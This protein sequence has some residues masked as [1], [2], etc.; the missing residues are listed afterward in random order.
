[1]GMGCQ[2]KGIQMAKMS[3]KKASL[4]RDLAITFNTN[5]ILKL[6]ILPS[7][8]GENINLVTALFPLKDNGKINIFNKLWLQK[9]HCSKR[10]Y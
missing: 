2:W 5:S 9:Y 4:N 10:F 1:M 8:L 3:E 6:C 7:N